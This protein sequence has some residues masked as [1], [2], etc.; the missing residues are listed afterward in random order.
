M[1][2][3][4]HTNCSHYVGKMV[5]VHTAAG[6][7]HG[8]VDR[9]TSKGMYLRQTQTISG[10]ALPEFRTLA[11]EDQKLNAYPVYYPG[12]GYGGYGYGGYGAARFFIPFLTI[13]ALTSLLF[14]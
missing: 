13:L 11:Q 14:W 12:Y 10:E 3:F 4:S 9:V 1:C 7:H 6:V 8:V 5:R 2:R